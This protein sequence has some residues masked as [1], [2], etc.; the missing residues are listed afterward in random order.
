MGGI[1]ASLALGLELCIIPPWADWQGEAAF[2]IRETIAMD[3]IIQRHL[4]VCNKM[5]QNEAAEVKTKES[6]L[7]MYAFILLLAAFA[8]GTLCLLW[9]AQARGITTL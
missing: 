3:G 4:H 5:F 8:A 6:K 1:V 7:G 2:Q 9:L